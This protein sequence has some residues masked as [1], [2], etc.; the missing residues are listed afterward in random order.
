MNSALG[1]QLLRRRYT[2]LR[3]AARRLLADG[4]TKNQ[5]NP[6]TTCEHGTDKLIPCKKCD[7]EVVLF[8]HS[9]HP[10]EEGEEFPSG[11]YH[12]QP[13]SRGH[14]A[15]LRCTGEFLGYVVLSGNEWSCVTPEGREAG[16][17]KTARLAA[18]HLERLRRDGQKEGEE[19][20]SE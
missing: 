13:D 1:M 8:D 2:K 14:H 10:P 15:F 3:D 20:C 9:E 17:K 11:R 6:E 18:A 5:G 4:Y 16:T 19:R 12:F 7:E